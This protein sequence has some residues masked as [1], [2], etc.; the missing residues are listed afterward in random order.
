MITP[1]LSHTRIIRAVS[2]PCFAA[3]DSSGAD[4]DGDDDFDDGDNDDSFSDDSRR[5]R[6]RLKSGRRVLDPE[7]TFCYS[8]LQRLRAYLRRWRQFAMT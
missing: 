8:M 3:A 1:G 4:E 5:G 2:I 6:R 7:C